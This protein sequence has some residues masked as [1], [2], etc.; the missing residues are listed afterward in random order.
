[1]SATVAE[2]GGRAR[3]IRN[4]GARDAQLRRS[5]PNPRTP[6]PRATHLRL[7]ADHGRLV[8]P[9]CGWDEVGRRDGAVL[10]REDGGP[11]RRERQRGAGEG[12]VRLTRRGRLVITTAVVVLITVTSMVLAS[13]AQAAPHL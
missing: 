12:P 3:A 13:V 7:V 1:V 9:A 6:R 2:R 11:A 5:Q 10:H 8:G 4:Q